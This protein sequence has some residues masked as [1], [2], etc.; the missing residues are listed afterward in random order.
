M[1]VAKPRCFPL[2]P[3]GEHAE[4]LRANHKYQRL[5]LLFRATRVLCSVMKLTGKT[6]H[7]KNKIHEAG[8]NEW[9]VVKRQADV[10]CLRGETGLFI[11]PDVDDQFFAQRHRRWV[12]ETNDVDFAFAFQG[13]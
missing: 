3:A 11:E 7:G 6:R 13:F 5:C 9:R 12:R 10:I 2:L 4:R 1:Q 8:T